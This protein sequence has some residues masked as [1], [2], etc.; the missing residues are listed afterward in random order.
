M[1]TSRPQMQSSLENSALV[2]KW[3]SASYPFSLGLA[4]DS[5]FRG[6]GLTCVSGMAD[7]TN[8]SFPLHNLFLFRIRKDHKS[9]C[10]S[11]IRLLEE[12]VTPVFSKSRQEEF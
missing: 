10:R 7:G 9:E 12:W 2:P 11:I 4:L 5:E 8:V 3:L 1:E 6:F